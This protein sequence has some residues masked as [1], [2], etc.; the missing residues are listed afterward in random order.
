MKRRGLLILAAGM[1]ATTAAA[2]AGQTPESYPPG[3]YPY[4]YWAPGGCGDL[5]I[6]ELLGRAVEM[7]GA[8][9]DIGDRSMMAQDWLAFTKKII[10]KDLAYRQQWLNAQRQQLA[11]A[12]QVRQLQLQVARLQKEVDQLRAR[13]AP[14]QQ[15]PPSKPEKTPAPSP[16]R[17]PQAPALP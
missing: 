9:N 4:G 2:G 12:R 15:A 7:L 13:S 11:Q 14:P 17:V 8:I 16:T 3:P 6:S 1:M 10:E 5:V